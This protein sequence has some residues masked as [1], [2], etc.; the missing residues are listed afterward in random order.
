MY[1]DWYQDI[2]RDEWKKYYADGLFER[3]EDMIMKDS[4]RYE[5]SFERN[6]D[7]WGL[8][9]GELSAEALACTTQMESAMYLKEWLHGRVEF[10][11]AHWGQD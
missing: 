4:V 9:D 11:N 1:E 3:A 6:I 10:L 7:R 2:I 8:E 5:A